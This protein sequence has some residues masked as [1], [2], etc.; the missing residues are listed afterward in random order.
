[1]NMNRLLIT[2]MICAAASGVFAQQTKTDS[3]KSSSPTENKKNNDNE[4]D[5]PETDYGY[6]HHGHHHNESYYPK[7]YIG[8]TL[9]RL[10]LGLAT[11][12]DNGS[13]TL[14]PKNSFLNYRTWKTVNDGFDV[15]QMGVKLK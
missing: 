1:M 9:S 15:F 6:W 4:S 13:F 8:L 12:I 2:A 10:D 5:D 7:P 3:V 11:L 14:S